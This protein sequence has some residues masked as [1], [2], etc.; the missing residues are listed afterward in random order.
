MFPPIKIVV[1]DCKLLIYCDK[2]WRSA[3]SRLVF[4]A[5]L[6]PSLLHQRMVISRYAY[7]DNNTT[8]GPAGNSKFHFRTTEMHLYREWP[9]QAPDEPH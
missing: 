2:L 1:L 5:Y 3:R 8:A 4:S 9:E 7:L 6:I